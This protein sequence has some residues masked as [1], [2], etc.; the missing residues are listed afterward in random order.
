M[1]KFSKFSGDIKFMVAGE[2]L[3]LKRVKT[4]K[5]QK[6]F[7]LSKDE[8]NT[9]VN[10]VQYFTEIV[11]SNYPDESPEE[12]ESFVQANAMT[13]FEEFQ[14]AYGL[15]KREDLDKRKQEILDKQNVKQDK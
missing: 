3:C 12:V 8:D 7:N 4:E 6:L 1:G 14:I 13:I 15:I 11:K 10:I 5:L 2:E 9:L